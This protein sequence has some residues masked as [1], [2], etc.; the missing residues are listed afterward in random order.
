MALLSSGRPRILRLSS[1]LPLVGVGGFVALAACSGGTALLATPN[2]DAGL[3]AS[4]EASVPAAQGVGQP[5][6]DTAQ[7]CRAGLVCTSGK[8]ALGHAT[9]NGAGCT[10]SGEC[11]DGSYCNA[12]HKCATAGT[13]KDGDGCQTDGDCVSGFR[14][15]VVGSAAACAPEGA[16]DLGGTCAASADCFG[17]LACVNKVCA[18][19][20]PGQTL[21]TPWT[22]VACGTDDPAPTKVYFRVPRGSGDGD[23][24]RLPFPNDVRKNGKKID[25]TSFPTP[26]AG[27]LG[28]DA[29]DRYLRWLEA[30]ADGWSAQPTVIFRFSGAVSFD[31]LKTSGA[32]KY[33]DLTT[34]DDVGFGWF[35]T[36]GRNAYVCDNGLFIR[37]PTGSPL[38]PGHTYAVLIGKVVKNDAGAAISAA[39]DF[40][41]MLGASA[42]ADA[43]LAASYASYAPLRTWAATKSF[44]LQSIAGGTVFTV[45]TAVTL[46]SKLPA[47][48][49]AAT[50]PAASGWV[51]CGGA[52]PSPCPDATGDRACG[53]GGTSF[54]EYHALVT[55]PV[56]QKG[57]APYK[58]P[59]DGGDFVLDG[60]GAPV[61]QR[62]ESVCMSLTVPKT[63]APAAG[64]PLVVYAH[65][66]GGHFRSHVTGGVSERLAT[67]VPSAGGA[68]VPMAVLGI[69]QVEHGPRRGAST[70]SPNTLFYN[71]TNPKAAIGNPL[72]GAADQLSLIRFAKALDIAAGSSPTGARLHF[73]AIAFWGHSQGATE[74]GISLPYS[75]DVAGVVLS[76]EGASLVDALL[77]KKKPVNV[78][79]AL[80]V[81]LGDLTVNTTHPALSV[82]QHAIDPADPLHHA[83]FFASE[84][85][86]T[87]GARSVFQPLGLDDSYSPVD[88]EVAFALAVGAGQVTHAPS[89]T[90]PISIGGLAE[91]AAPFKGNV[92]KGA[93]TVT[94][95]VRQ[96]APNGFDGHF[97]AFQDPTGQAD[98][99]RFLADVAAGVTP[100]VGK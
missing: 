5:C 28:F 93:K 61:V 9:D 79:G 78:A 90:T 66:T 81:L 62:T 21:P 16:T 67:A 32:I 45:G 64:Y 71:F 37:P 55:L 72:Q 85:P 10:L 3:D 17:G 39:E 36:T 56:F 57:T 33:V 13:G 6:D 97:V 94:V 77:G 44:D 34:G 7:K 24:F 96:Y 84:P 19:L 98:V 27:L 4:L 8:C 51:K 86:T 76:G 14:C 88:S 63:A 43:A 50:A 23:F 47:A 40:S 82:L 74:G 53:T 89:V 20:P 60:T 26:G 49:A 11:K 48:V 73:G 31:S 83:R 65:G 92:K 29:L 95:A 12:D 22:G 99:D 25:L 46:P 68:A 70:E 2:L 35:A 42:P 59:D 91:Q 87:D 18:Q 38:K 41:A 1:L 15:N 69:D 100:A 80:P 54:D 30:T 75:T 58:N 52:A